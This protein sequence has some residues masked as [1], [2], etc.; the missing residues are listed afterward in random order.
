MNMDSSSLM[1][2]K[3]VEEILNGIPDVIKVFN[4]DH[5][6]YFCNKAG[7][8]FY[9]KNPEEVEGQTCYKLL[10]RSQRC[11]ECCFSEVIKTKKIVK[12]ERYIPELNKIMDVCYNPI[13]N[14]DGEVKF[15]IERLKD[16]TEKK[17]LD[18]ILKN[19][20]ERYKQILNNSPDA[21]VI[22]VDNKIELTNIEALNLF[23]SENEGVI[24]SNIYKYFNEKYSKIMHKRFR[25]IIVNKKVKDIYDCELKLSSNKI[26]N[27]QL[28]CSYI[29]Y[30]GNSAILMTIRDTSETRKELIRA[31]QFQRSSLQK[32]FPGEEFFKT[33][34]V[35]V[36][37]YT[38]SGDFYR[39]N[40]ISD[41]LFIGILI[42]V[43]G[44]GIS[45][46]L[47]ISALELMYMEEISTEHNLINIVKN[48]NEK[49]ANY[50]EENYIAV[51]C[52]S[53]DFSSNEFKVVGAGINQFMFQK[54]GEKAE[55]LTAEGLFLGMFADSE[56]I[57]VSIPIQSGDRIFLFSDGFDF[58]FDDDEIVKRYMEKV[59]I[60]EFKKYIDEYLEDTILDEGKLID[61][62]TMISME[63]K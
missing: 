52:F 20:K 42:D 55:K 21:L 5:T 27:V 8:E 63:I 22:I 12:Q 13:L 10:N 2:I 3:E 31:A 51:C 48:L 50:Y 61:D 35:Y 38:I 16:I 62:C 1:T 6:V 28:S 26:I 24:N 29:L 34:S 60:C 33:T 4:S 25:K 47:N 53:L 45:A 17:T 54:Q 18:K 41:E 19:D 49:L 40:K 7:Y 57:E 59:S 23:E 15:V 58:I 11:K 14:E 9:N 56:F 43:K 30:E 44:K 36:P 32:E 39:L 37:A 46:A